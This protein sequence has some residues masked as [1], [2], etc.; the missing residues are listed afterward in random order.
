MWT[1]ECDE[2]EHKID[3][4]IKSDIFE[5]LRKKYIFMGFYLADDKTDKRDILFKMDYMI[6]G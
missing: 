3:Y 5:C 4:I 6:G 1:V 2:Y